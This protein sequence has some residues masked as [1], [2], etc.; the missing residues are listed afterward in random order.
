[1]MTRKTFLHTVFVHLHTNVKL[2][3]CTFVEQK[4]VHVA[5]KI[6]PKTVTKDGKPLRRTGLLDNVFHSAV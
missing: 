4:C 6:A 5:Q 2:F 1:M 3:H